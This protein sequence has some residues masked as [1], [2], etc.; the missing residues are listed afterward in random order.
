[1]NEVEQKHYYKIGSGSITFSPSG[2]RLAYVAQS[3]PGRGWFVVIDGEEE[4][5]YDGVITIG[6][7]GITFDSF[8]A[9]HYLAVRVDKAH[10]YDSIY[11]V[12]KILK[13]PQS[14]AATLIS[15]IFRWICVPSLISLYRYAP[16]ET[17]PPRSFTPRPTVR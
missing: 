16:L 14:I 4:T 15:N 1:M 9:L 13:P 5:E 11:R 17:D 6:G 10:T 8:P 2:D 12:R 3:K 7:G